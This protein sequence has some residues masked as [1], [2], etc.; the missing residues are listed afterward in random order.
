LKFLPI[1]TPWIAAFTTKI[2]MTMGRNGCWSKAKTIDP[3][4]QDKG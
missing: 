1:K 4:L 2:N 3:V